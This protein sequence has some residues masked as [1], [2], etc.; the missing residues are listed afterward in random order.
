[1]GSFAE[2][3]R[4]KTRG[5]FVVDSARLLARAATHDACHSI[6]QLI[7]KSLMP[8]VPDFYQGSEFSTLTLTDPDNRSPVDFVRRTEALGL[9]RRE[10]NAA[11]GAIA[12]DF[13]LS[14]PDD[15]LKLAVTQRLLQIRRDH[16]ALMRSGTYQPI[17]AKGVG[18]H[19]VVGFLR[20]YGSSQLLV[21]TRVVS[22]P[23]SDQHQFGGEP[24]WGDTHIH[25][26]RNTRCWTAFLEAS[27]FT[28][29]AVIS[30]WHP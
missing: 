10:Q 8:G 9:I 24:F 20:T 6:G 7:L 5:S 13:F 22:G 26:S 16:P 15:I 12:A 30:G 18:A 21:V 3:W 28:A 27:Q 4:A 11:G 17:R 25:L 23:P 29:P 19:R 2:Y 1:M 14:V